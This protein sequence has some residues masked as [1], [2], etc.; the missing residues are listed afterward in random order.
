MRNSRLGAELRTI[1]L[2]LLSKMFP[3]RAVARFSLALAVATGAALVQG[4]AQDYTFT[5]IAGIGGSAGSADGTSAGTSTP[6]LF[7]NP[8]GLVIDGSGNLFVA[9]TSNDAIRKVTQSGTVTTI[10]GRTGQHRLG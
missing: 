6:P 8:I 7:N 9:D 5:T 10:V 3:G 1:N 2:N 4:H